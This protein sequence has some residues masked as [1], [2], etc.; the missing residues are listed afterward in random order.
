MFIQL[1]LFILIFFIVKIIL[2][3][4]LSIILKRKLNQEKN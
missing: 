2:I 3:N 1:L 4:F